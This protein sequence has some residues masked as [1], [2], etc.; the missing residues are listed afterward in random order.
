M[1]NNE[2][3]K[4]VETL[5][6]SQEA[7]EEKVPVVGIA[8]SQLV[9][10]RLREQRSDVVVDEEEERQEGAEAETDDGKP[11]WGG[12]A[13][14]GSDA[15]ERDEEGCIGAARELERARQRK[16]RRIDGWEEEAV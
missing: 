13:A 12:R 15:D 9:A 14:V 10:V 16:H 3:M 4:L 5:G 7:D 8:L 2:L 6:A 11:D 1:D